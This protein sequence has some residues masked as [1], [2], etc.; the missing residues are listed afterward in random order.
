MAKQRLLSGMQPTGGALHLG[1]YEGALRNW[2]RL[3]EQ[4][5]MFCCIVDWHALT[6]LAE[7]PSE[8]ADSCRKIAIDYIAAGI[9]PEKSAIFIQSHVKEHAELHL[10]LSMVTPLSWLERVP[11][12][13]EKKKELHIKSPSYGLL[14]YPVLQAADILLYKPY[15]VPVGKD[16][17]AHLE[18][19]REICRRFNSLY[20]KVFPEPETI[21]TEVPVLPGLD[22]RKM[23]KSYDNAIYLADDAD[24]VARKI[25]S[26]FTTP[27]KIR[28]SDPGV[29]ENCVVCQLRRVYD[30]DGYQ[31]AWD[32]CRSGARGCVQS[33]RELT[34][35]LNAFLDPIRARRNELLNDL[36]QVERYL[37]QG[38]ERARAVAEQTMK[39]VRQAMG[40]R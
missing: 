19:T 16:Q 28:K 14:G 34:D 26:A 40:L 38:A 12:F 29:P 22:G 23:S 18:L 25:Q 17:A 35:L 37:Q 3:Q 6:T 15:G 39:E 13:K 36:A 8:I 5:E 20:G 4:Y 27:T 32:E 33:K 11:T 31:V 21:L 1:N 30:P 24:T 10:L 2:V 7:N 9:N